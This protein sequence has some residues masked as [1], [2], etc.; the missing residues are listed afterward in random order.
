MAIYLS[1][2]FL[3]FIIF[4]FIGWCLEVLFGFVVLKRFVNRGFLMMP[5]CPLYGSGC[6]ILYVLLKGFQQSP[7][8]LMLVSMFVCSIIEYIAS[9]IL[10]KIFKTRWWDYKNM[11]LKFHINGRI[12][13]EMAI[14]FGILGLIDVYLVFPFM[15]NLLGYVSESVLFILSIVLLIAFLMDLIISS[16]LVLK[17]TKNIKDS[18]QDMTEELIKY[19]KEALSKKKN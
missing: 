5:L 7:I 19:K 3:C 12:C 11:G 6:V 4:S 15:L 18:K 16:S 1:K 8:V 9:F 10:E 2:L 13:L 14:P 17:F